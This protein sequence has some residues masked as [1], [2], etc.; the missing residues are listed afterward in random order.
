MSVIIKQPSVAGFFYPADPAELKQMVSTLLAAARP[1]SLN[2]P[3][4]AVIVPHAGLVYSG[5]TAAL[6]YNAL[7]PFKQHYKKIVLLAPAHRFLIHGIAYHA[8]TQFASPLGLIEVETALLRKISACSRVENINQAFEG[9]HALEVQFPFL[10]AIFSDYKI[11]PLLVGNTPSETVEGVLQTIRDESDTLILISS[12][13][14]HYLQYDAAKAIDQKTI[15]SILALDSG[16]IQPNQACGSISVKAYL[17]FAKK[18]KLQ[19]QCLGACNS[20]DT[21]GSK[22]R[23]VGYGSF[24]FE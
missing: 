16:S 12:D 24:C 20:G 5:S 11:V 22:D 3:P 4:K 7:A 15:H 18:N 19:A 9:E 8:A 23:V 10:Q 6:V 13:L 1:I 17:S 2:S 14:S 21:V